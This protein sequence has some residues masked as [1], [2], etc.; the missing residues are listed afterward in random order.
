MI[1]NFISETGASIYRQMWGSIWGMMRELRMQ[2]C[3]PLRLQGPCTY[4]WQFV[5]ALQPSKFM[6]IIPVNLGER[7]HCTA[8]T[9]KR[10]VVARDFDVGVWWWSCSGVYRKCSVWQAQTE[11]AH[12]HKCSQ[13]HVCPNMQ[14]CTFAR[15]CPQSVRECHAHWRSTIA[16][17]VIWLSWKSR[18]WMVVWFIV[19]SVCRQFWSC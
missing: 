14:A 9:F 19:R 18:S 6:H 1:A 10:L 5:V 16:K 4:C 11:M 7:P 12:R 3:V 17:V 13:L 2:E 8:H 15:A